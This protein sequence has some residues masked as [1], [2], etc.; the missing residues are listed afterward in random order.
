MIYCV[1]KC[2]FDGFKI[3]VNKVVTFQRFLAKG[4]LRR[5][6]DVVLALPP[7]CYYI[8][9]KSLSRE[10]LRDSLLLNLAYSTACVCPRFLAISKFQLMI[11]LL[12]IAM[13]FLFS[14]LLC[15]LLIMV[16]LHLRLK[17]ADFLTIY[18]CLLVM[19]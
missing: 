12:V 11:L 16:F 14:I 5:A 8:A 3:A 9:S 15:L 18:C 6:G 19:S 4:H 2:G 13:I 7:Y 10:E 17:C 1:L